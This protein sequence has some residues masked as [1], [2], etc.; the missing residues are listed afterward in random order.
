MFLNDDLV[1]EFTVTTTATTTIA[2]C[3]LGD[4]IELA[5]EFTVTATT[6]IA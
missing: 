2:E 4:I 6:T 5:I 1:I 3:L